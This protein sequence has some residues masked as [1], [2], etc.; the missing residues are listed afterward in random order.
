[1]M[2]KIEAIYWLNFW[3]SSR[4]FYPEDRENLLQLEIKTIIKLIEKEIAVP[5]RILQRDTEVFRK[6]REAIANGGKDLELRGQSDPEFHDLYES[7]FDYADTVYYLC[8]DDLE[9]EDPNYSK[10]QL[11]WEKEYGALEEKYQEDFKEYEKSYSLEREQLVNELKVLLQSKNKLSKQDYKVLTLLERNS[12]RS[13]GRKGQIDAALKRYD[14]SVQLVK[15]KKTFPDRPSSP[16]IIAIDIDSYDGGVDWI[17][18]AIQEAG[19]TLESLKKDPFQVEDIQ[20]KAQEKL[21][22]QLREQ[23]LA[24]FEEILKGDLTPKE[25]YDRLSDIYLDYEDALGIK[26]KYSRYHDDC[27]N[28]ERFGEWHET[29]LSPTANW[30]VEVRVGDRKIYCPCETLPD[31]FLHGLPRERDEEVLC[32]RAMSAEEKKLFPVQEVVSVLGKSLREFPFCLESK[33]RRIRRIEAAKKQIDW[34]ATRT[35]DWVDF[36]WEDLGG[37]DSDMSAEEKEYVVAVVRKMLS[38]SHWIPLSLFFEAFCQFGLDA[39]NS[40]EYSEKLVTSIEQKGWRGIPFV[41]FLASLDD[42]SY[43]AIHLCSG[44]HRWMALEKLLRENRIDRNFKVPVFDL[45]DFRQFGNDISLGQIAP[46]IHRKFVRA[47]VEACDYFD[48]GYYS[49]SLKCFTQSNWQLFCATGI[50][51]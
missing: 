21:L 10:K 18:E 15:P 19:F 23:A 49:I 27:R 26:T 3:L 14:K 7:N 32:D 38:R 36:H 13:K 33:P 24:A 44:H 20:Y 1:M 29:Q 40:R 30:V 6:M 51:V 42:D 25:S 31:R 39:V 34:E 5:V 28:L 11:E 35:K 22:A 9:I 41:S 12:W 45:E 8:F 37:D 50:D 17:D 2:N 16:E 46:K 43:P 47:A 4:D 48:V